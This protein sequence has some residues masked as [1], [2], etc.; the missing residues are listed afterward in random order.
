MVS[1]AAALV[2][3]NNPDLGPEQVKERLVKTAKPLPGQFLPG[4]ADEGAGR[5]DIF[6]AV[7]NGSFETGD[8]TGWTKATLSTGFIDVIDALQ[9]YLPP[10][11][12]G[13]AIALPRERNGRGKFMAYVTTDVEPGGFPDH[14]WASMLKLYVPPIKPDVGFLELSLDY[15]FVTE[16]FPEFCALNP[17]LDQFVIYI[18]YPDGTNETVAESVA[19]CDN[20]LPVLDVHFGQDQ[21]H[22]YYVASPP[23]QLGCEDGNAGMTGWPTNSITH[24]IDVNKARGG[25]GIFFWVQNQHSDYYDLGDGRRVFSSDALYDMYNVTSVLLIDNIALK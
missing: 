15:N 23:V 22:Y 3:G 5:L 20:L 8:F 14:N 11:P 2:W 19:S 17:V 1:A 9:N 13:T 25:F 18:A 10:R 7:F 12:T 4:I 24:I 16:E 21:C 6:E